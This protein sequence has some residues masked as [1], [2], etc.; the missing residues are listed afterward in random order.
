M[1]I[2]YTFGCYYYPTNVNS[3]GPCTCA[4]QG[5][6]SAAAELEP[7]TPGS[8]SIT[9]PMSY[10]GAKKSNKNYLIKLCI[11]K[12]FH[13]K[14]WY[15]PRIESA[16]TPFWNIPDSW[17]K[18]QHKENHTQQKLKFHRKKGC[19]VTLSPWLAN[20]ALIKRSDYTQMEEATSCH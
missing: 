6:I 7:D 3:L 5:N 9:L 8:E 10:P 14:V 17:R 16:S 11:L 13:K 12:Y 4:H 2:G 15:F 1:R 20:L 19:F 18:P